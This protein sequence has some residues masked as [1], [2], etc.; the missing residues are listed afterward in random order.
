MYIKECLF[1]VRGGGQAEYILMQLS[2]DK[3]EVC[4][5]VCVSVQWWPKLMEKF[6]KRFRPIRINVFVKKMLYACCAWSVN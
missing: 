4:Y 6:G 2:L 5:Y 3:P 1:Q